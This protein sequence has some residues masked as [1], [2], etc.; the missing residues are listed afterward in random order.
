MPASSQTKSAQPSC[1][2]RHGVLALPDPFRLE[3]GADIERA[4]LTW[5]CAGPE[6]APLVV[7][8]GGISAHARCCSADGGGWWESQCGDGRA[9]DTNRFQLLGVDWLGGAA[10]SSAAN[11]VD[12]SAADQARAL[13]LLVNRLGRRRVHL[14]VGASY[15]GCVA[16][17]LAVLLGARLRH[18][19]LLCSAHR[20]SAFA[21]A[22]RHVQRAI[23]D[24]G[25]D[26]AAA[27]AL[28][29]ELAILGYVTAA[30]IESRFLDVDAVVPWLEHHGGKFAARFSADAYRCLG[31]SLDTHRIDPATIRMPTILFGVRDDVLVPPQLLHEF[32][33]HAACC[34]HVEISSIH[35][36][37]AFLKETDAVGAVLRMALEESP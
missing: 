2:F 27:L 9:L 21:L 11:G 16:Q 24:L 37:D 6:G 14:L 17:H 4:Q 18:L 20:S 26:S 7:V 5:Q 35:G 34:E 30:E 12:I 3:S 28:A 23:L 32:A 36:H 29:R 8:L 10:A 31:R 13:L 19:V 33:A 15:G 25:G 22:L 1:R